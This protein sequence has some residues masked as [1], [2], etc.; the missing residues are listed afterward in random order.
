M[1]CHEFEGVLGQRALSDEA[2]AHMAS[3]EACKALGLWFE[4]SGGPVP[5]VAPVADLKP[6]SPLPSPWILAA[7]ILAAGATVLALGGKRL[8]LQGWDALH[9]PQRVAI[10]AGLAIA[11][12]AASLLLARQMFPTLARRVAPPVCVAAVLAAIVAAP[13]AMMPF[14]YDPATFVMYGK[15]CA[16]HGLLYAVLAAIP[17]WLVVRRGYFVQPAWAGALTGLAAGLTALTI[18]E[19]YCPLTEST[20]VLVW[21]AGVVV[22][23]VAM[24]AALAWIAAKQSA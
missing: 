14:E 24:A 10:F 2:R 4:G 3:C 23:A 7:G 22:A 18:L 13:L 16:S 17:I 19:L 15:S 20:H 11:G 6:V 8:G 12:G 5:A 21:H 1:T 9:L